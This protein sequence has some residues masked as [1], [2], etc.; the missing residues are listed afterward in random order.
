MGGD[1]EAVDG[2]T[3]NVEQCDLSLRDLLC[4]PLLVFVVWSGGVWW[5]RRVVV[6]CDGGVWWR[7]VVV[8]C[9][10]VV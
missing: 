8:V 9:G 1:E 7:C 6:V 4:A 3:L 10:G 5:W 2:V